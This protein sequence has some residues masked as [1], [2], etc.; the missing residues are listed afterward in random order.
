MDRRTFLK[1]L[2]ALGVSAWIPNGLRGQSPLP[3]SD[4]L[5]E[6]LPLRPLGNTG[7]AVTMLGL[8]GAHLGR[9]TE[10]EAERI[11]RLALE[12]GIRFFDNAQV[13]SGGRAEERYG[14]YLPRQHRE[15]L[16]LMSKTTATDAR[17][18]RKD[19]ER[20]LRRMRTDYLDLWQVH[21][22]GSPWDA[23]NRQ[24]GGI[25][26][27]MLEAQQE[28]KVRFIGFTGHRHPDGL[29]AMLELTKDNPIFQTC[30]M[31]VNVLDAIANTSFI[32]AVMPKLIEQKMGILA[33]KTLAE[34]HFFAK[35]YQRGKLRW[36]TSRPIIPDRLS[37]GEALTFVWSLPISVLIT[38]AE[39]NAHLA[40]KIRLART[41]QTLSDA[42]KQTILDKIMDLAESQEYEHYKKH[43]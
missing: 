32:E 3:P 35:T 16:F 31:P 8:G 17:T 1:S 20:S 40:E 42:E 6:V 24:Q 27:V 39:T 41:F 23:R 7:I 12:G 30:Q 34:G 11:I 19:L 21:A 28:G 18:A 15:R 43:T 38:G 22:V 36:K 4:P 33:M 9:A 37:V 25:F 13:Y 5:G 2:L 29:L 14:K 26:E 10:K